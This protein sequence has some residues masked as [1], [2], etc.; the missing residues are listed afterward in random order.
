MLSGS[1]LY[2]QRLKSRAQKAEE[3]RRT[4][5]DSR[6]SQLALLCFSVYDSNQ[7]SIGNVKN[8]NVV[9]FDSPNRDFY[10]LHYLS[11]R[12][13]LLAS[14]G[15]GSVLMYRAD[16]LPK[17]PIIGK[18]QG[19]RTTRNAALT[20]SFVKNGKEFVATRAQD[21]EIKIWNLVKGRMR[22]VK[23]VKAEK[24]IHCFAYLEDYHMIAMVYQSDEM[25]F[26]GFP[27]GK[28]EK[29]LKLKR[30]G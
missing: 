5:P 27:S 6:I 2:V 11:K 9:N 15:G 25:E 8:D 20:Q 4:N 16:K 21:E 29:R 18:F 28:L 24:K 14:P 3:I 26:F 23:V 1:Y 17:L 13:T 12:K 22:L 19:D 10:D 30:R 7:L